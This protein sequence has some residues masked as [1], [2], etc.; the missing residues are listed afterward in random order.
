[1]IKFFHQNYTVVGTLENLHISIK[2]RRKKESFGGYTTQVA[3]YLCPKYEPQTPKLSMRSA[4]FIGVP[5]H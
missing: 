4:S 2:I 1:M 5:R 3:L